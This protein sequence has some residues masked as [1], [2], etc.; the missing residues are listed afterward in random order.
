MACA[1]RN[2]LVCAGCFGGARCVLFEPALQLGDWVE[3][4]ASATDTPDLVTQVL[5]EEVRRDAERLGALA[6][7]EREPRRCRPVSP[8]VG[9]VTVLTLRLGLGL[10]AEQVGGETLDLFARPQRQFGHALDQ[11]IDRLGRDGLCRRVCLPAGGRGVVGFFGGATLQ[12]LDGGEQHELVGERDAAAVAGGV[13][14]APLVVDDVA[15]RDRLL[16]ATADGA[17]CTPRS[18]ASSRTDTA[19]SCRGSPRRSRGRCAGRSPRPRRRALVHE[20]SYDGVVVEGRDDA[21]LLVGLTRCLVEQ[22]VRADQVEQLAEVAAQPDEIGGT[23]RRD[24]RRT[25]RD[26]AGAE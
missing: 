4:S 5:L 26:A 11:T 25:G 2:R 8:V 15:E 23:A 18:S 9:G 6:L 14:G 24:A 7:A 22:G 3:A 19:L 21:P 10:G 20:L 1:T 16:D 12:R 13:P 17:R